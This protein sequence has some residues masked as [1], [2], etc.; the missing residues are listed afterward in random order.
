MQFEDTY[1][2]SQVFIDGRAT[3]QIEVLEGTVWIPYLTDYG[4]A[5]TVEMVSAVDTWIEGIDEELI[6]HR[7]FPTYEE[8]RKVLDD[9]LTKQI[10]S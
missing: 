2:V 6:C 10:E 3:M 1:C 7:A 4:S 8:A 5:W 9:Y